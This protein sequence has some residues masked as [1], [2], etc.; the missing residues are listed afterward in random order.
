MTPTAIAI[1]GLLCGLLYCLWANYQ[2]GKAILAMIEIT[3]YHND[4]IIELERNS[5]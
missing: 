2:L 3:E 5:K 4:R 1:L